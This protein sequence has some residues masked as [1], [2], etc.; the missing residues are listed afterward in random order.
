MRAAYKIGWTDNDAIKNAL[1]ANASGTKN[2]LTLID[3]EPMKK[4]VTDKKT[5]I[6]IGRSEFDKTNC[7][8]NTNKRS[9]TVND[10]GPI[11]NN[12]P[13]SNIHAHK[14][15]SVVE[16]ITVIVVLRF[17]RL[18]INAIAASTAGNPIQS[19]GALTLLPPILA[20]AKYMRLI[21]P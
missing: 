9:E 16:S 13:I 11:V 7:R 17:Q 5:I 1:I 2:T 18:N 6:N 10:H 19:R 3:K 12:S 21:D 20:T 15:S 8:P 4:K 14:A